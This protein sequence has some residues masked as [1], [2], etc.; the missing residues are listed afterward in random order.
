MLDAPLSEPAIR[1]GLE[2]TAGNVVSTVT[3]SPID[4]ELVLPDEVVCFT[5]KVCMP[6]I[7]GALDIDQAPDTVAIVV[8]SSVVPSVSYRLIVAPAWA[9]MPLSRGV[10]SLVML[11]VANAPV[12]EVALRSG[13]LGAAGGV[14]ERVNDFDTSGFDI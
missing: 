14:P 1:S 3:T 4:A 13:A 2:G 8:P 11:S 10:V 5:V 7:N 12:S 6:S 9:P